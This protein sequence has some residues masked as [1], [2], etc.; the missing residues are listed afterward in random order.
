[1]K[2]YVVKNLDYYFRFTPNSGPYLKLIDTAESCHN[3]A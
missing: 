1:V 3:R 2:A